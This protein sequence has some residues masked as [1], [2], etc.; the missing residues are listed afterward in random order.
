[1]V[2]DIVTPSVSLGHAP[3]KEKTDPVLFVTAAFTSL[4]TRNIIVVNAKGLKYF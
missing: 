4:K 3:Q 1:M 2:F